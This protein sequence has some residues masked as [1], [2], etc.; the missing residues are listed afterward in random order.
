M[1]LS[2]FWKSFKQAGYAGPEDVHW[3]VKQPGCWTA[4]TYAMNFS[5]KHILPIIEAGADLNEAETMHGKTPL[6]Y[7]VLDPASPLILSELLA[8]GVNINQTDPS[9]CTALYEALFGRR[10]HVMVKQLLDAGADPNLK[11]NDDER[12]P[13][14]FVFLDQCP[15]H[16]LYAFEKGL[17]PYVIHPFTQE[18]LLAYFLRV[19]SPLE[20]QS[21]YKGFKKKHYRQILNHLMTLDYPLEGLGGDKE[22]LLHLVNV[23]SQFIVSTLLQKKVNLNQQAMHGKTPLTLWVERNPDW[24]WRSESVSGIQKEIALF[25]RYKPNWHTIRRDGASLLWLACA[26]EPTGRSNHIFSSTATLA[27]DRHPVMQRCF[28]KTLPQQRGLYYLVQFL[29]KEGVDIHQPNHHGV[30]P[31]MVACRYNPFLVS[32]LLQHGARLYQKTYDGLGVMDCFLR[33][34]SSL[35]D[36]NLLIMQGVDLFDHQTREDEANPLLWAF[37]QSYKERQELLPYFPTDDF[38]KQDVRR[39]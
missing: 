11:P 17:D 14:S 37:L 27:F 16:L 9:G 7:S 12:A 26:Q 3:T 10:R 22:N 29:L 39:L 34:H 25:K 36:L 4:L 38:P 23:H 30:T 24:G 20:A 18:H 31:L 6:I 1:D 15:E 19:F 13:M 21:Q 5:K 8:R 32:L 33:S 35:S 2:S 28:T